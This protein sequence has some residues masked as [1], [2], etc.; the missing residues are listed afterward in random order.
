MKK[1]KNPFHLLVNSN[2]INSLMRK[3]KKSNQVQII[4]DLIVKRKFK[5]KK[6]TN[7]LLENVI[8]INLKQNKKMP[9]IDN[10]CSFK[11]GF[12]VVY[13]M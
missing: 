2:L 5:N 7:L 4:F 9:P 3:K 1:K 11:Q 10:E 13:G 12:V 6:K 8:I